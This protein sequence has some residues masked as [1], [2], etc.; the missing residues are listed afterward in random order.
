[1]KCCSEGLRITVDLKRS[2][3]HVDHVEEDRKETNISEKLN[4]VVL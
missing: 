3:A 1:M 2:K 4:Y